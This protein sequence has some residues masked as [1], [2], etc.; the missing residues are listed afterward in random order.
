[1]SFIYD[2]PFHKEQHGFVGHV[3]G[4]W[5]INGVHVATTGNPFTPFENTNGSIGLGTAYLTSGDRAF[6]SNPNAPKNSVA[7]SGIDAYLSSLAGAPTATNTT[8]TFY[9]L[10]LRNQTGVWTPVNL[11]DVRF[12]INGP[13]AAKILGTP[14]GSMPRNYLRGPGINQ[15]NMSVFKNTKV[16]ERVTVQFRAE[17][18]NVLNHPNPGYGVNAAGYL[19]SITL[20]N[21]GVKGNGFADFGDIAKARRVIQFGLKFMF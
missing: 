14:F 6:I 19:P 20:E 1:M 2:V 15:L 21:A 7:I 17:A 5:Q 11:S 18:F 8:T 12:I 16:G 9:N 4:G 3:L 13:G 10:T